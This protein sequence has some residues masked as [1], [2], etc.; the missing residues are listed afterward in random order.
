[1][2]ISIRV[3]LTVALGL[4]SLPPLIFGLYLLAC[5]LRIHTTNAYYVEYPYLASAVAFIAV[6]AVIIFCAVYGAWRRSFYGLVFAIAVVFGLATMVYVPDGIPHVHR[7][8]IADFN[9]TSRVRSFLSVWYESNRRFP[10]NEAEF[11]DALK[12]GPAAWQYRVESLPAQSFYSQ[13][14]HRLPYQLVV[15]NDASGPRL[16]NV[17]DRPGVIYYCVSSDQQQ[18]WVTMTGLHE[19]TSRTATLKRIIDRPDEKPMIVTASGS[20]YP[21]RSR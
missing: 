6:A 4:F 17:S 16:D 21:I 19:N 5:S 15:V 3:V 13:R 12:N 2:R 20:D 9:Y 7:S 14:G 11:N 1:M 10:K 8:M 18:Y